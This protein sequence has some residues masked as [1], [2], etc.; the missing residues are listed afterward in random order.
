MKG[1][2]GITTHCAKGAV[3]KS[4]LNQLI[5]EPVLPEGSTGLI[6]CRPVQKERREAEALVI[7]QSKIYLDDRFENK[8]V[9]LVVI[10]VSI[11]KRI[12]LYRES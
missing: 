5:S 12:I 9:V 10:Y 3:R 6:V 8:E 11:S 4:Q 2:G 7:E 1:S